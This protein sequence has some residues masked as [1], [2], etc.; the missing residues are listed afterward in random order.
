MNTTLEVADS[1]VRDS[2]IVI[3][4]NTKGTSTVTN[5]D[6]DNGMAAQI[7][8]MLAGV[9][10]TLYSIQSQNEKANEE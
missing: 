6:S 2:A 10:S 4:K 7:Q 8:G 3:G 5:N 1:D 9:L